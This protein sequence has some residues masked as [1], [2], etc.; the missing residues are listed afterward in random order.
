MKKKLITAGIFSGLFAAGALVYSAIKKNS[1]EDV[2][3]Y[4]INPPDTHEIT[5]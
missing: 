3:I 1:D 4:I 5:I 2:E